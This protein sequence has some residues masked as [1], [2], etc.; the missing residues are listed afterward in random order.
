MWITNEMLKEDLDNL[1]NLDFIEWEK[2]K[3]KLE[4]EVMLEN[5]IDKYGAGKVEKA[6][7]TLIKQQTDNENVSDW[8]DDVFKKV[9]TKNEGGKAIIEGNGNGEFDWQQ[10]VSLERLMVI[11]D[12]LNLLNGGK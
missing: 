3:N 2:F 6:L 4:E 8:A 7:D 12:K 11:L 5:L 9:T 1:I 10:P